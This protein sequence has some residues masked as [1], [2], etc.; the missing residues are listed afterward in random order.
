[1][2]LNHVT[3]KHTYRNQITKGAMRALLLQDC[4]L[5]VGEETGTVQ[6]NSIERDLCTSHLPVCT[7]QEKRHAM[8]VLQW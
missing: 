7:A 5:R 2:L 6:L 3:S 4:C 8:L 1:M